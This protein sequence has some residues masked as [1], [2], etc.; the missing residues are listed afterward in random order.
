MK[1]PKIPYD[2]TTG[3]KT[4]CENYLG[5]SREYVEHL[6]SDDCMEHDEF[7]NVRLNSKGTFRLDWFRR[8]KKA[9]SLCTFSRGERDYP[10]A[11]APN[12][13]AYY[14]ERMERCMVRESSCT[15]ADPQDNGTFWTFSTLGP[16]VGTGQGDWNSV[17]RDSIRDLGSLIANDVWQHDEHST[18]GKLKRNVYVALEREPRECHGIFIVHSPNTDTY[19]VE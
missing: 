18:T 6:D 4:A 3:R 7:R 16:F 10:V 11:Y 1:Q 12:A 9:R 15:I 14:K 13:E 17:Q 19:L 8:M 2:W 5:A